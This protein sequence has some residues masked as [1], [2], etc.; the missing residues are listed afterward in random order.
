MKTVLTMTLLALLAGCKAGP[1]PRPAADE[2]APVALTPALQAAL[3]EDMKQ[4]NGSTASAP[5]VAEPDPPLTQSPA[6]EQASESP[7][8]DGIH[9]P[10]NESLD[11]LQDP[12][13]A[14]ADFPRDRR[15]EVDWVLALDEELIAPR[16]DLLGESEMSVLDMDITFKNT[17][18]MPWVLFPHDKHT[19]WLD[20]SNCHSGIFLPKTGGN[21]IDMNAV[22][23]G[24][25][26]GVCHGK[27][28]FSLFICERCHS[29]SHP[30]SGPKW[31]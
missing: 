27:V 31:W 2:E 14:M 10:L 22:L 16:A 5:L 4:D 29:V 6:V 20:C 11:V 18:A 1:E 28:S 13:Q 19:A 3:D 26:C 17:G 12:T 21:D 25:Y 9:D 23:A 30:G 7:R 8:D 24:E 15:G